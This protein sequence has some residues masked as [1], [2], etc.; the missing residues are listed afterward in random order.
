[1]GAVLEGLAHSAEQR[2]VE[3]HR[4][5]AAERA[6]DLEPCQGVFDAAIWYGG[7]TVVSVVAVLGLLEGTGVCVDRAEEGGE[8]I[9]NSRSKRLAEPG[10]GRR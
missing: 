8:E 9:R 7:V 5:L 3:H 4:S 2:G 10:S 1:M 6:P